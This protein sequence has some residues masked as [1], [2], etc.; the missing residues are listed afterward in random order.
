MQEEE[1][2]SVEVSDSDSDKPRTG[3]MFACFEVVAQKRNK[4][5][6]EQKIFFKTQREEDKEPE[7]KE[8]S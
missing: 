6:N 5:Q 8:I 4:I 1:P 3:N 2:S 7:M